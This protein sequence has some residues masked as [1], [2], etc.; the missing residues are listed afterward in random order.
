MG[1]PSELRRAPA[2]ALLASLIA[3]GGGCSP[4]QVE[5]EHRE[6]VLGLLTAASARDPNLLEQAGRLI[7]SER[8][9]G[10]LSAAADE[11]FA[12]IVEAGVFYYM[13][14][15]PPL[16]LPDVVRAAAR[17]IREEVDRQ[18]RQGEMR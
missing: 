9:A 3:L 10:R 17:S 18:M 13:A 11:A 14:A 5:A 15:S 12:E 8:G 16:R 1:T 2:A 7:E 4:P 6:L